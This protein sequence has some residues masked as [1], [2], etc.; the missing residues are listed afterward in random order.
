MHAPNTTLSVSGTIVKYTIP[1]NM[2]YKAGDAYIILIERHD[3]TKFV[4]ER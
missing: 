3:G 1:D 2:W 4:I